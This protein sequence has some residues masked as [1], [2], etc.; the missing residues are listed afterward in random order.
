[1]EKKKQKALPRVLCFLIIFSR[2]LPNPSLTIQLPFWA[3]YNSNWIAWLPFLTPAKAAGSPH[4]RLRQRKSTHTHIPLSET[5]A[6]RKNSR[7]LIH[8]SMR[9]LTDTLGRSHR[10]RRSR[11][12]VNLEQ[13]SGVVRLLMTL[14]TWWK[15]PFSYCSKDSHA[16]HG[17]RAHKVADH[18]RS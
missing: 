6:F 10:C 9:F 1:M 8:R 18:P 17:I 11:V 7:P 13:I 15:V 3:G 16:L 2:F 4:P 12:Y 14:T 5:E